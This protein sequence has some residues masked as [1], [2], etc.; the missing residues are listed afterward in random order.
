MLLL[1]NG[2]G[3]RQNV[4]PSPLLV[5]AVILAIFFVLL[6]S[7]GLSRNSDQN[8]FI[9]VIRRCSAGSHA[10]ILN[11]PDSAQAKAFNTNGGVRGVSDTIR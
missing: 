10:T 6:L 8:A 4:P 11:F 2:G 1:R 3:D 7:P 9:R 5:S